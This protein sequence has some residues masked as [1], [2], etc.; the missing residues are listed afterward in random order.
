[1]LERPGA[2]PGVAVVGAQVVEERRLLTKVSHLPGQ[3]QRF[4]VAAVRL[5]VVAERF[6]GD[7]QHE[8]RLC[9]VNA[10]VVCSK[11]LQ[12]ILQRLERTAAFSLIEVHPASEHQHQPFSLGVPSLAEES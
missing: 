11:T 4:E 7:P 10:V 12:G 9:L 6:E 8:Q 3:S 1:M 2:L 5:D